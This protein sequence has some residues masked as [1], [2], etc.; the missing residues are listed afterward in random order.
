MH[1][2]NLLKMPMSELFSPNH[3]NIPAS[4]MI[5]VAVTV[6]KR[7]LTG[8]VLMLA[9]ILGIISAKKYNKSRQLSFT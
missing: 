2:Y 6:L 7:G 9:A 1:L 5:R 3:P 8:R 4:L